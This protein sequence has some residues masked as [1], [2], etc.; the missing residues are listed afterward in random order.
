MKKSIPLVI[1]VL[2]IGAVSGLFL[3]TDAS[4]E[5]PI[6]Y[7]VYEDGT[8]RVMTFSHGEYHQNGQL[9]LE[10]LYNLDGSK[11]VQNRY[12]SDGT[13]EQQHLFDNNIVKSQTTYNL[14]GIMESQICYDA[15]IKT[16][17]TVE[18]LQ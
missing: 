6:T 9:K 18:H 16:E 17:C 5:T 10:M 3:Q 13:L 7:E 2:S 15:E 1:I 4:A 8:V 12:F 11:N 14:D